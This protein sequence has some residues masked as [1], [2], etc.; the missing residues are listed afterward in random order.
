MKK[1]TTLALATAMAAAMSCS[2]FAAMS[3]DVANCDTSK[4]SL[5]IDALA[6]AG[7]KI[8]EVTGAVITFTVDD[9]DGFGGGFMMNSDSTGWLQKDGVWDWGNDEKPVLAEGADGKYTLTV[10]FGEERFKADETY[11]QIFVQQWWGN[12]IKVESVT[13]TGISNEAGDVAPVAYLAAVAAVA[14]LAMVAS[15]KR[16]A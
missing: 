12:D 2:A 16:R 5:N 4:G 14:G 8:T 3:G 7:D 11:A 6:I 10:N 13:L 15:K 1:F 9:T